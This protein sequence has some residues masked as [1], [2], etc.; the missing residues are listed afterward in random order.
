MK[1]TLLDTLSA[2][3]KRGNTPVARATADSATLALA[4][5]RPQNV[6][7]VRKLRR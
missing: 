7:A 2:N 1:S 3:P 4:G 6:T 5:S